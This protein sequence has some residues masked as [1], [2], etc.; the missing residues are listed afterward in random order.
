MSVYGVTRRTLA[1]LSKIV[2]QRV[3]LAR[4][5]ASE[6]R[7]GIPWGALDPTKKAAWQALGWQEDSWSGRRQAPLSSLQQWQ[8]LGPA[9]QAAV[10]HGLGYSPT[11]WDELLD[12][13][14]GGAI[15]TS[16]AVPPPTSGGSSSSSGGASNVV[17]AIASAA[18]SAAPFVGQAL[19]KSKSPLGQALGFAL[20]MAP[21]ASEQ[22][23]SP[24]TVDGIETTLY[25]DDSGS[26]NWPWPNLTTPLTEG[27]KVI[28]SLSPLLRGPTRILKFG[29]MPTTIAPREEQHALTHGLMQLHWT[30][31]SGGTY[32]WHMIQEDVLARYRPGNGKL[33][34]IVVTDGEDT[35]SPEGYNGVGGM[36]PM[37]QALLAAG[38][39]IEWHIVVLGNVQGQEKYAALAGAT[40]GSYLRVDRGSEFDE[41]DEEAS[42]FLNAL[43]ESSRGDHDARR[44]R[45]RRY[46]IDVRAG[47][48]EPFEWYKAL[49]PSSGNK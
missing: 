15:V 7:Q 21:S 9:E 32:M 39:D 16:E 43:D 24:V 23:S 45:Q 2:L 35:Q 31:D 8:E 40:G 1:P 49:P 47:K 4:G 44:G 37:Q 13:D 27:R 19:S 14:H 6:P 41:R 36:T 20:Q 3:A 10:K 42:R 48:S 26:M 12:A 17:S 22:F 33:R 25:L 28:W 34:L 30:G 11:E 46:E 29:S 38:F 18:F 5:L